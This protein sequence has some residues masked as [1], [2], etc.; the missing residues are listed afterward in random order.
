MIHIKEIR[1]RGDIKKFMM[2]ANDLYRDD[3]CYV[4]D[5]LSSQIADFMPRQNPAFEYC[6]AKCFLACRDEKIVGRIAAIYNTR[7]CQKYGQAQLRF[8]HADYI[9]DDEVVDA[10]FGAVEAWA[11]ELGC[12][13]VHGP[14]GFSDLDREGMLVEGFG[15]LSQ[16]FVYYNHPY[17]LRQMERRGYRKDTDWIEH[18]ITLP[19]VYPDQRL[20][21]LERLASGITQRLNLRPAPLKGR[22]SI[23]PYVQDVF[24]LYNEAYMKL[25]GVVA[26]SPA[27]INKYVKEFLPLVNERTTAILLN[28][29]DEVVAFGVVAPSISL[30]Q[31]KNR[32][33]MF[34]L[35]WFHLL[36]ALKGKNDTLDLLLMAVHPSLQGRGVSAAVLTR[37]L[38]FAV[39]DGFKFAE[40][41]PTLEDNAD[42]LAHWRFFDV[43][44][45][46]RRRAFI[47]QL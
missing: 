7:A 40:T 13:S 44:Q 30:A 43:V 5:M 2:F 21:K 37:L 36:K 46:K 17:Y 18:R 42:I 27:Q 38:K 33:K 45:H 34:P 29:K 39:E 19:A 23:I 14:L 41:G 25:Y 10:L 12:S 26:L 32:G 16:F 11:A 24:H 15:Q 6:R 4:P 31:Q 20:E 8:S 9:D 35:G 28:E 3:P 1:A 47:K 22:K